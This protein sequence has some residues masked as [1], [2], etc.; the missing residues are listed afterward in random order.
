[1]L[2]VWG[3]GEGLKVELLYDPAIPF[4]D[5]YPKNTLIQKDVCTL[6]FIATPFKVAKIWKQP[7]YPLTDEWIKKW[8]V[9]GCTYNG[10]LAIKMNEIMQFAITWMD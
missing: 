7:T 8:R 4:L 1:M 5:I 10:I 6:M 3:E 2:P 9:S